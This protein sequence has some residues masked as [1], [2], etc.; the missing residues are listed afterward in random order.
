MSINRAK[1]NLERAIINSD[2][3]E[4]EFLLLNRFQNPESSIKNTKDPSILNKDITDIQIPKFEYYYDL[5]KF[6]QI[7]YKEKKF[8]NQRNEFCELVAS[9]FYTLKSIGWSTGLQSVSSLDLERPSNDHIFPRETV[10]QY[11]L[12]KN[13]FSR[14]EFKYTFRHLFGLTNKVTK[15]EN[16]L[17]NS[18]LKQFFN[19]YNLIGNLMDI[20]PN[21]LPVIAYFYKENN[22]MLH[23]N[24]NDQMPISELRNFVLSLFL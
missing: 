7:Y 5:I 12:T 19:N 6:N 14:N 23:N 18:C 1:R 16:K 13:T 17:M 22:I 21:L 4:V 9:R 15:H 8:E 20:V 10:A 2:Y 3:K 24:G 11:F